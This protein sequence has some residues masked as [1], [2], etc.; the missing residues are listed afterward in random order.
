MGVV[1]C[2][3]AVAA[4]AIVVVAC[5]SKDAGPLGELM[6][7]FQSDM[8]LPKDVDSVRLLITQNGVVKFDN[9]YAVGP[10][11]SQTLPATLGVLPPA[12]KGAPVRIQL[13]ALQK[14]KARTL[15]EVVTTVPGDRVALLRLPIEWLCDGTANEVSTGTYASSCP[16]EQSCLAGDCTSNNVDSAQLPNYV[17]KDVFGGGDDKG[18]GGSCFETSGCFGAAP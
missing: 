5:S 2:L 7:S 10:S 18:A 1:R 16:G 15:R 3:A 14:G 17:A 4:A 12:D 6:L 8:S 11:P 9:Q 13:S